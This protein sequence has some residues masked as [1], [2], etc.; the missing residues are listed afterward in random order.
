MIESMYRNKANG[1]SVTSSISKLDVFQ[2]PHLI[3]HKDGTIQL[4]KKRNTT[5]VCEKERLQHTVV[6]NTQCHIVCLFTF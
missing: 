4:I 2:F 3:R 5:L 1:R 6:D